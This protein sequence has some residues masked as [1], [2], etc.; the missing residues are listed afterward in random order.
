MK[1]QAGEYVSLGKVEMA[2][3]MSPLVDNICIY[4]DSS[5]M[6]TVCLLVP[7]PKALHSLADQ[8]GVANGDDWT[9]LCDNQD[10]VKAVLKAMQEQGLK[11][12]GH[13][14]V[15]WGS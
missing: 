14:S 7:N 5:K 4:A 6:F 13:S 2:L 15:G 10:I 9:T 3:K 1:L 8:L 12:R 11:G